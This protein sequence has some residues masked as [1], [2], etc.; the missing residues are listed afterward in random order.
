LIDILEEYGL[1]LNEPP[2]AYTEDNESVAVDIEILKSESA[3]TTFVIRVSYQG[4][5]KLF[6]EA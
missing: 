2:K 1:K 4:S 3:A 6:L 5:S